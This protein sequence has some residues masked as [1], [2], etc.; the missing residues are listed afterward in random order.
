MKKKF[1]I[2]GLDCAHCASR[3][4]EVIKKVE[5]VSDAKVNFLTQKMTLTVEDDNS[6]KILEEVLKVAKKTMPDCTME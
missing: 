5:G 4:E 2:M 1:K 6:D 3:L